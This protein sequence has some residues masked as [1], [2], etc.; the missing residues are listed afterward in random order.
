MGLNTC[1]PRT[2]SVCAVGRF[3]PSVPWHSVNLLLASKHWCDSPGRNR[4]VAYMSAHS[5]FS[6]LKASLSILACSHLIFWLMPYAF[7]TPLLVRSPTPLPTF[8][9]PN[10]NLT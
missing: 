9:F 4:F 10:D 2:W 7:S 8:L 3:P 1:C 6:R 5:V